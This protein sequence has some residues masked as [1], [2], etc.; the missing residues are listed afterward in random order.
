MFG[1]Y[2]FIPL[3]PLF[4]DK[5]RIRICKDVARDDIVITFNYDIAVGDVVHYHISVA[6]D[7][8]RGGGAMCE[9][10]AD[11]AVFV[12][13]DPKRGCFLL[14]YLFCYYYLRKHI[15]DFQS[16]NHYR[17]YLRKKMD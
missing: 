15:R 3:R 4:N 10:V 6:D 12:T 17:F 11:Y 5:P 2:N 7:G 13:L 8:D 1:I 14:E 9:G 16:K